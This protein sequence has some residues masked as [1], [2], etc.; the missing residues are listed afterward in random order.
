MKVKKIIF[1]FK[2]SW[3]LNNEKRDNSFQIRQ[4]FSLHLETQAFNAKYYSFLKI[5]TDLIIN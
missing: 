2:T 5:I 4:A 1:I 3:L